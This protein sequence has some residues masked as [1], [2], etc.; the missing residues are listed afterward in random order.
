MRP[1]LMD[2]AAKNVSNCLDFD[3]KAEIKA[4]GGRK[5]QRT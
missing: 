3:E 5:A 2:R 4:R 1:V